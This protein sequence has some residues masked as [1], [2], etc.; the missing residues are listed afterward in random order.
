MKNHLPNGETPDT[1]G[2]NTTPQDKMYR[3][4]EKAKELLKNSPQIHNSPIFSPKNRK[5]K[6][7]R[8]AQII[9]KLEK[10]E[11][12]INVLARVG[13]IRPRFVFDTYSDGK[14]PTARKV[15]SR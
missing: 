10:T 1:N 6:R 9:K 13:Y 4:P 12:K 3:L 5:Y 14:R 11:L 8:G 7:I 15:I 2:K